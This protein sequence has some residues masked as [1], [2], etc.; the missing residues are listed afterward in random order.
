[1]EITY[2]KDGFLM[3]INGNDWGFWVGTPMIQDEAFRD[4][5]L[6]KVYFADYVSQERMVKLYDKLGKHIGTAVLRHAY[7][8]SSSTY[9]KSL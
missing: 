1:M 3:R 8:I 2:Q 9:G 7:C 5:H 4:K 6:G